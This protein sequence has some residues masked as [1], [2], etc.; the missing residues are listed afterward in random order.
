MIVLFILNIVVLTFHISGLHLFLPDPGAHGSVVEE[1][2]SVSPNKHWLTVLVDDVIVS[3]DRL[4][5][6]S[7]MERMI[8]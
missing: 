2:R 5:T 4:N 3:P 1:D 8:C 7:I 6:E